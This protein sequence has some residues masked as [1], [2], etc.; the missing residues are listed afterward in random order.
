MIQTLRAAEIRV[1]FDATLGRR[2]VGADAL[3]VQIMKRPS[4]LRH[5]FAARGDGLVDPEYGMLIAV[6]RDWLAIVEQISL[7]DVHVLERLLRMAEML[8]YELA[9][10]I[11]DEDQQHTGLRSIFKPA[12]IA[13]VDL[14]QLAVA[15]AGKG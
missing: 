11:V 2:A 12:M 3:D 14:H 8:G 13:S 1:V 10:G 6:K 4:E 15:R 7:G 5:A 9:C